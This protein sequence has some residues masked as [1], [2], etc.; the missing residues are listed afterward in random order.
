MHW[1]RLY[2]VV[3]DEALLGRPVSDECAAWT[4]ENHRPDSRAMLAELS[5]FRQS[6]D[7]PE[8]WCDF[9]EHLPMRC[10]RRSAYC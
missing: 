5:Y 6:E 9:M 8:E 10:S 1:A 7:G 3:P 2:F 4:L